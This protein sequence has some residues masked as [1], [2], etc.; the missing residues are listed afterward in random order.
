MIRIVKESTQNSETSENSLNNFHK[1]LSDKYNVINPKLY[2]T[3]NSPTIPP[4]GLKFHYFAVVGRNVYN[5][6][7][8]LEFSKINGPESLSIDHVMSKLT[9][10]HFLSKSFDHVKQS[11]NSSNF[12]IVTS[13]SLM[14]SGDKFSDQLKATSYLALIGILYMANHTMTIPEFSDFISVF[15]LK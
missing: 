9:S 2:L 14:I 8:T 5:L 11:F 1:M 6:I 15:L 13:Y 10:T 3:H 12:E 4:S 7:C